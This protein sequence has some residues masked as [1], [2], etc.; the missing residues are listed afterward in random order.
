M[1]SLI[2]VTIDGYSISVNIWTLLR[3]GA[4]KAEEPPV[5]LMIDP[6]SKK[7]QP[8]MRYHEMLKPSHM[9]KTVVCRKPWFADRFWETV[10]AGTTSK[11]TVV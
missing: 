1:P 11:K 2:I 8:C 3:L 6:A 5:S 7:R 9:Q 4:S 10:V